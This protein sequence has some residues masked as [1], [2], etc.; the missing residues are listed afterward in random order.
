[1]LGVSWIEG[2]L[3]SQCLLCASPT[4]VSVLSLQLLF[5]EQRVTTIP[6]A[7]AP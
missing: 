6:V 1:V 7:A 4:A 3:G 2:L 5:Y